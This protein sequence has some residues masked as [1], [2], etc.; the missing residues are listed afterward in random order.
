MRKYKSTAKKLICAVFLICPLLTNAQD[1]IKEDK[2]LKSFF[3]KKADTNVLSKIKLDFAVPDMPAFKALGNDPSNLLRPSSAKEI[4][5]MVGSFRNGGNSVIPENLSVEVAP[6]LFKP[7]YTLQEYRE[8]AGLR[9]LTKSRISLGSDMN[10]DTKLNSLAAGLRFTF[11]DKADFRKD[12]DFLETEIFAKQD[13]YTGK[14]EK[15][16][17]ELIVKKGLKQLEFAQLSATEQTKINDEALA[18]AIKELGFDLDK[19]V[20][21][22]LAKYKKENW[23]ASKIDFAYSIVAQSKDNKINN[24]AISKHSFWLA[25]AIKPG[26]ANTWGQILLGINNNLVRDIDQKFYNEFNGNARFYVGA[27]RL[28]GFVE[29]QYKNHYSSTGR[30]E[31]LYAQ[32]GMELAIY[33]SIW[34]HFGTGV[35]N[36]LD[37]KS[38]SQ[39]MGNLNLSLALPENLSL[40]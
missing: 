24:A 15:I 35:E 29:S 18:L 2:E 9:F 12:K 23:N 27:N 20:A 4:A 38:K 6:A 16:R 34:I 17:N 21:N 7:W 31:T 19:D 1:D 36:A 8:N 30:N 25:Y 28:K 3:L 32:L 39:L 40:F 14:F 37:G 33:K 13:R 26:K 5:F 11:L 22:A 10:K